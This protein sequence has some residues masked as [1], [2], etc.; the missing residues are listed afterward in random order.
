M[1]INRSWMMFILSSG[2]SIRLSL[3]NLSLICDLI[4]KKGIGLPCINWSGV[5]AALLMNSKQGE[6]N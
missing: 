6:T 5:K 4:L 3:V 2:M 1:H